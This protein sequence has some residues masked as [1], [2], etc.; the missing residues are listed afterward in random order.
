M[1]IRLPL[2]IGDRVAID[3][4]DIQAVVT[5][6]CLRQNGWSAEC[7]W[8]NFGDLKEAWITVD[9]LRVTP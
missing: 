2:Q 4:G 3:G 1:V 6:L 7:A 8:W 5:A 9:R